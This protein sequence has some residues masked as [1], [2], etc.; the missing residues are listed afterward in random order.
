MQVGL[1]RSYQGWLRSDT[2]TRGSA[3]E[4]ELFVRYITVEGRLIVYVES[5]QAVR[6]DSSNDRRLRRKLYLGSYAARDII[7]V[8]RKD[9]RR[10]Q[11]DQQSR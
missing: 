9:Y 10:D 2:A 6:F 5:V 11:T 1:T 7:S 8:D 3:T 4:A